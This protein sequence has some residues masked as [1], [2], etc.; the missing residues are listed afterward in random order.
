MG[1]SGALVLGYMLATVS[2]AA[3]QNRL[4]SPPRVPL[5]VLAVPSSTRRSSSRKRMKPVPRV[6]LTRPTSTT[7]SSRS[8]SPSAAPALTMWAW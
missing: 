4:D 3:A 7:A 6:R 8:G 5:L 2:V 1:D